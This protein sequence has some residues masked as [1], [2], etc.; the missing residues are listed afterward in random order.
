MAVSMVWLFFCLVV[1]LAGCAQPDGLTGKSKDQAD[2]APAYF[3]AY[4]ARA[5]ELQQKL[6]ELK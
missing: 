2:E 4:R 3:N 6:R 1:L 5:V